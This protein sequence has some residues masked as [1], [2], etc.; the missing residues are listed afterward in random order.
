MFLSCVWIYQL[1]A[2]QCEWKRKRLLKLWF[3]VVPFNCEERKRTEKKNSRIR[4]E[5]GS[6]HCMKWLQIKQDTVNRTECLWC[7]EHLD[8]NFNFKFNFRIELFGD[9]NIAFHRVYFP[10]SGRV[11]SQCISFDAKPNELPTLIENLMN[12]CTRCR[13]CIN[14]YFWK[15]LR[16]HCTYDVEHSFVLSKYYGRSFEVCWVK[17]RFRT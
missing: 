15:H 6:F 4:S 16:V 5:T 9:E 11:I 13:Q 10:V 3:C 7:C 2:K 12:R 8:G 1:N 17:N 14:I